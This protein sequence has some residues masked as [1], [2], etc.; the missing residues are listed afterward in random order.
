M[1]KRFKAVVFDMDSVIFD[2]ERAVIEV[3]KEV[4]KECGIPDIELFCIEC[5]GT[6]AVETKAKFLKRYGDKYPYDE[7]RALKTGRV[8][9]RFSKGLIDTKKGAKDLLIELKRNGIKVALASSTREEAVREELTIAG[10]ID[11]FDVIV[12]GDKVSNSKPAPDIFIL[13][14][15]KLGVKPCDAIGIEDSFNGIRSSH[16]AGLFTI[17]VPDILQPDSE[18]KTLADM[19]MQN[20]CEVSDFL[21]EK[22]FEF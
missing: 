21:K 18:I 1:N 22:C 16:A 2:T 7:I 10:L 12:T 3:W 14:C 9:E 5:L 8:R 17:M 4:A 15:E 19:I 20:L 6:N 11:F 13:A